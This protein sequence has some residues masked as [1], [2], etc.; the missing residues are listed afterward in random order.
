MN[1]LDFDEGE[2]VPGEC[3]WHIVDRKSLGN[4]VLILRSLVIGQTPKGQDYVI[5]FSDGDLAKRFIERAKIEDAIPYP[6]PTQLAWLAFLEDL[7]GFGYEYI[8]F[9]PEPTGKLADFGTISQ[10]IKNVRDALGS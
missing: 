8:G 7:P 5:A 3:V 4:P 2:F 10:L 1:E 6:F 9:D